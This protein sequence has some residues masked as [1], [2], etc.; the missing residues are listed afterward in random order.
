MYTKMF[1]TDFIFRQQENLVDNQKCQAGFRPLCNK[2]QFRY[3][4]SVWIHKNDKYYNCF[5]CQ[6]IP[7]KTGRKTRKGSFF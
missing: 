6:L 5:G 7:R 1:S 4:F 3:S 2:I